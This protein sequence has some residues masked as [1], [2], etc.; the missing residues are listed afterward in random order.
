MKYFLPAATLLSLTFAA[1]LQAQTPA[2]KNPVH[3]KMGLVNIKCLPSAGPD[4]KA[5]RANLEANLKRHSWFIDKL[6]TEGVEFVGFPE[7][8]VNGYQFSSNMTWLSL[9]GPEVKALQ[10]K[11]IE[12]G[13]YISVGIA[14]Q[15]ADG[16]RWNTQIV[17]DPQGRIIGLH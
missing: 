2:S 14:E 5:N 15:D 10:K 6:A 16:K 12:K 4:A 3:L 1:F 13:I 11:A 7:L 9:D 8:S 17:I